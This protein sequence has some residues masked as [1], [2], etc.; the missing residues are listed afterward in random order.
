MKHT[1]TFFVALL[2]AP[3]ATMHAADWR[4]V[5]GHIMTKWADKVNPNNPLP[6]YPRPQLVRDNWVTRMVKDLDPTRLVTGGSG[7]FR[8]PCGDAVD[9]HHY[10]APARTSPEDDRIGVCGEFGGLGYVI[11]GHLW[12]PAQRE[13]SV[14]STCA[15]QQDYEKQ[16]LALWREAFAGDRQ[17]GTSAA[18]YTELTDIEGEVNGLMTYDRKV[19]KANVDLFRKALAKREF[20]PEPTVKTL[21]PT[22]E[23]K[24]QEWSYTLEKPGADWFKPGAERS[25][26]QRGT[27]VFGF[28]DNKWGMAMSTAWH[29]PDIWLVRTF[30]L[31]PEL[32]KRPLLRAA[33]ARRAT[34]YLNGVKALELKGGYLMRYVEIPLPTAAAACLRAGENTIA[35][36]AEKPV[37]EKPDNQFIDVGLGDETITWQSAELPR[38]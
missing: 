25:G 35:I 19:V 26:W 8:A 15:D 33:Y 10:Q 17:N 34:V 29:S 16:F 28:T 9:V 38:R 22:S 4:P 1:V 11:P 2:L 37:A 12:F 21:L 13:S 18:V 7:W 27:G 3:L 5:P 24:P 6:E 31:P 14:Y 30:V 32:V 23:R 36:H 20:P